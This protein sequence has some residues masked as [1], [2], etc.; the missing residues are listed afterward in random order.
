MDE[1]RRATHQSDCWNLHCSKLELAWGAT[2]QSRLYLRNMHSL[3]NLVKLRVKAS[4]NVEIN[5]EVTEVPSGAAP[6]SR[7][8]SIMHELASRLGQFIIPPFK[9]RI[10]IYLSTDGIA[11]LHI[12]SV[13]CWQENTFNMISNLSL[14]TVKPD[15]Q[16]V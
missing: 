15:S 16:I 11:Q 3:H 5:I 1:K 8:R 2:R 9:I 7:A 12:V 14:D 4:H 10:R 6:K 13:S